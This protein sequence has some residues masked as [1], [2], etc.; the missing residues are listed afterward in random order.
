M[1]AIRRVRAQARVSVQAC[2]AQ[3]RAG[4][5]YR[6]AAQVRFCHQ[7][8]YATSGQDLQRQDARTLARSLA[9]MHARK[10]AAHARIH[11][12]LICIAK[13]HEVPYAKPLPM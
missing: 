5:P 11:S 12:G 9:R 2:V 10:H 3:S 7:L 13:T 8:D 1:R 6:H 4:V